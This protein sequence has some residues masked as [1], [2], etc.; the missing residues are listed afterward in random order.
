MVVDPF[1]KLL[2]SPMSTIEREAEDQYEA[3]N[4]PSPVP[5]H[6]VDSSYAT[7]GE[8]Q[9]PV[10]GD[11]AGFDDPMIAHYADTDEQLGGVSTPPANLL[12]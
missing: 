9:V 8:T 6:V 10:V 7:P 3:E 2:P 1:L 4:D 5:G 12:Y 11:E